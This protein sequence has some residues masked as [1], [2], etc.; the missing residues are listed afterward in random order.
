MKK[1]DALYSGLNDK[2]VRCVEDGYITFSDFLDEYEQ[3]EVLKQFSKSSGCNLIIYS[4]NKNFERA[5]AVFVPSFLNISNSQELKDF[6]E[7]NGTCPIKCILI[8]KDRFSSLSHRDYL[9]ALMGL[10][11]ERKMLG[12]I[13][14]FPEGAYVFVNEKI[15]KYILENLNSVGRGSVQVEETDFLPESDTLNIKTITVTVAS[16]RLD[17]IVSSAFN[18][19]RTK[20]SQAIS[21]GLVFQN[22]VQTDKPDLKVAV[23]DKIVL[24]KKGKSVIKDIVGKSRKD[25]Y[26]VQIDIYI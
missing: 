26:V 15:T 19:S 2:L 24:R 16:M 17:N 12:D 11:I 1:T 5:M 21:E 8:K 6:F 3:S 14:V 4:V 18:I 22:G 9:G 10:G 7:E 25:R 13:I 23:G 20:A